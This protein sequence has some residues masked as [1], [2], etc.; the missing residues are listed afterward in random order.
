M[1]AMEE[2]RG[3]DYPTLDPPYFVVDFHIAV[4]EKHDLPRTQGA[5]H[6]LSHGM[7]GQ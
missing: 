7:P 1:P 5:V 4:G 2:T 6:R 3:F